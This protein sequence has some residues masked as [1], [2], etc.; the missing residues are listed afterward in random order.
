[1]V[2]VAYLSGFEDLGCNNVQFS[3]KSASHRVRSFLL[4]P[5]EIILFYF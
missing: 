4:N 5:A 2:Y 1:M 3:W